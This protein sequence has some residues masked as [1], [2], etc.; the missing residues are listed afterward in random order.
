VSISRVQK[1]NLNYLD[2]LANNLQSVEAAKKDYEN[3]PELE[4]I[5]AHYGGKVFYQNALGYIN[6]EGLVYKG[7]IKEL[8]TFS[9][10]NEGGKYSLSV[11][12]LK[13]NE[14]IHWRFVNYGVKGIK[15]GTSVKGYSFKTPNPSRKMVDNMREYI[16]V[17][18]LQVRT[19]RAITKREQKSEDIAQQ[20]AYMLAKLIKLYGIKPREYMEK[21][22]AKTFDKDFASKVAMAV[23]ND[24][25]IF[26]RKWQ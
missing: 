3:L 4:K 8:L 19:E 9:I 10:D 17:K 6:E 26:I 16:S 20:N 25:K 7:S 11:G 12:Y 18:G 1:Q 2:S 14:P 13:S 24:I 15:S 5:L 22:A 21:A 23:G